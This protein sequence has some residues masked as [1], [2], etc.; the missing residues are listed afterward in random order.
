M[1]LTGTGSLTGAENG[2]VQT[3]RSPARTIARMVSGSNSG[4]AVRGIA[5]GVSGGGHSRR[6]GKYGSRRKVPGTR[7]APEGALPGMSWVHH[8]PRRQLHL[9][10]AIG[11]QGRASDRG[12]ARSPAGT[13]RRP[14][15]I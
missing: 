2:A 6:Q 15:A 13:G 7:N 1:R 5:S 11:D 12:L 9:I 10:A 4:A 14:S 3:E 8:K